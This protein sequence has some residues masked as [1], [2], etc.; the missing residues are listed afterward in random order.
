MCRTAH[1]GAEDEFPVAPRLLPDAALGQ[2]SFQEEVL[3]KVDAGD[4]EQGVRDPGAPAR[5]DEVAERAG[6][7]TG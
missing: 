6:M 5:S 2:P 7:I 4:R 1:G 3:D